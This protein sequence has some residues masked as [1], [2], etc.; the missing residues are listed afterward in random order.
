MF[1]TGI[2]R[3]LYTDTSKVTGDL[4]PTLLKALIADVDNKEVLNVHGE[5]WQLEEA[6]ASV[7]GYNNQLTGKKYRYDQTQMGDITPAWTIGSYDY[8]TKA[9][10]LGG[11]VIKVD[12]K[13]V[14]WKRA[15]GPVNI[16]KVL[17]CLTE[18]DVWFVFPKVK[19]V[20]RESET[21]KAVGL[22]V[23]GMVMEPDNS[24]VA[25]EYN[26]DASSLA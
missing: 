6:E 18:D 1:A 7:N 21:D 22:A 9:D 24:A 26:F 25:S 13:A 11:E 15:S 8:E 12:T 19:V 20:A 14:G 3:I 17:M 2:K 23:K 4:T 5:T 16:N 10:L